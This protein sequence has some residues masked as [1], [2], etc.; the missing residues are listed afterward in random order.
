MHASARPFALEALEPRVLLN[1]LD[2]GGSVMACAVSPGNS[3]EIHESAIP[4]AN[5]GAALVK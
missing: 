4:P 5:S 1:G 3:L 2:L